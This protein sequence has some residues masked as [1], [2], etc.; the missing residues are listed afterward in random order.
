MDP[1]STLIATVA[2]ELAE[3]VF[4]QV[5]GELPGRL[6]RT[7]EGDPAKRAA[8]ENAFRAGLEAA[9][10]E[11]RAPSR[12]R[13]ERYAGLLEHFLQLPETA[14]ELGKLVDVGAVTDDP[15]RALDLARLDELFKKT[16]PIA[17]NAEGYAGLNF[18]AAL[19][20]FVRA[21]TAAI[22]K[23]ADKFP[24]I[25]IGLLKELVSR[26]DVRPSRN[27]LR[28]MY[29]DWL[30]KYCDLLP[31]SVFKSQE[32]APGVEA[33]ATLRQVYVPLDMLWR[34]PEK[35]RRDQEPHAWTP[36]EL[37]EVT[38]ED[39]V[40]ALRALSQTPHAVLLGDP[41]S[42]KTTLTNHLA[43]CLAMDEL[44][45]DAAWLARLEEWDPKWLL[46]A[47][48][49]LRKFA[50]SAHVARAA[51]GNAGMV[52]QF[53]KDQ[54]EEHACPEFYPV[55]RAELLEKGGVVI[56]D[57][58]DEVPD[59]DRRR[60]RVREAIGDFAA[61]T[62]KCRLIVTCRTYA[63]P[64]AALA[65]FDAF[66]LL[67]FNAEQI[68]QFI[69][70]WYEAVKGKEQLS[71]QE[72]W[73]RA[74]MLKSAVNPE[75][76]RYIAD[77]ATR[78]L[79]LTLMAMVY[80]A[81]GKLPE[82]RADLYE[83]CVQLLLDSW[84]ERKKVSG[85]IE[86]S[87]AEEIGVEEGAIRNALNRVAYNAH[88][89]QGQSEKRQFRSADVQAS[90]L[91]SA[92]ALDSEAKFQTVFR[93]IHH[94]AGLVYWRGGD[95]YAFPHRSFQEY[96]AACH[97]FTLQDPPSAARDLVRRDPEWWREVYLLQVGQ[98]RLKL[99]T[100]V[101]FV[102][103]LCPELFPPKTAPDLADWRSAI[104]AGQALDELR[105]K[106]Q[107]EATRRRGESAAWLE[108]PLEYVR[109]WLVAL[110]ETTHLTPRERADAG[111]SLGAL[112]DPRD[113][114]ELCRVPAG[115]FT[116]GNDRSGEEREK[117]AHAVFVPE[118]YIARYPVTCAQYRKFVGAKGYE[119]LDYWK[120]Q[121]AKEW[122]QKSGQTTPV[123][124]DD[125][126][127]NQPNLPVVGVTWFEANA[128]CEWLTERVASG[129]LR[130]GSEAQPTIRNSQF[131]IRLPTE[132]E[133]E[134]AATW[135]AERKQKRVYPWGDTFD[136]DKAN[137]YEGQ[138]PIGSTTPVGIYPHG[139]S[140]CGALDMAGNVWE[141][142][143]TL[144]QEY[145][146]RLDAKHES[147]EA[148]GTRVWRGGSWEG[149]DI[150]ARGAFRLYADPGP[151]LD[152]IGLRVVVAP[153]LGF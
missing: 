126:R 121:A 11:M 75:R 145:P 114:Y 46:P 102:T 57:G 87:L 124:W 24:W 101:G 110:L 117:P 106:E 3:K 144:Y 4:V 92:L 125:P 107:I 74:A 22:E 51:E 89:R 23:Q 7:I 97:L 105:L 56:L 43:L 83:R 58:L 130:I 135:D 94:R 49:E 10:K 93:Y 28:E 64:S 128:Y 81:K 38:K 90:D 40:P 138:N 142:C 68:A 1:L 35:K 98:L 67:P 123:L 13:L 44:E 91:K 127:W 27:T 63:Y 108:A 85:E 48:I 119:K 50:A 153:S 16:F 34:P 6:R 120:T 37:S 141:W 147:A 29:L 26:T 84:Q 109:G 21:Y 76:N 148:E 88:A 129:E 77:L 2:A 55:F 12:E 59:T 99:G 96:L 72:A 60:E 19:R 70:K 146:Y 80:A 137:T 39:R 151:W 5:M 118:F 115:E 116:M 122:L 36:E 86:K 41:G 8:L 133:W 152:N 62:K 31:L 54:M 61:R 53:L 17:E 32:A 47:R 95:T 66:P 104:L 132:A 65:G 33:K 100:A 45:P 111:L 134:K 112:G 139:A 69:D 78:P 71:D 79:L 9:L 103:I 143:N 136:P 82:D 140:P 25:Q 14:E 131:A 52:W 73:E 42:G 149:T 150:F 30:A 15:T 18:P 20:A 113:L